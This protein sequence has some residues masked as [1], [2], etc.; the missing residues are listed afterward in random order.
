MPSLLLVD[1]EPSVI[2]T[3][4]MI[5]ERDGYA[6]STAT[7]Y[8][9]AA[10]LLQSESWDILITELD[11][12]AE[13][14]G[15]RLASEAKS[16]HHRPAIFVY[17]SY[18]NVERLRAALALRVDYCAFKPLEVDEIRKVVRLLLARNFASR[19]HGLQASRQR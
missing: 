16:L 12:E 14:L 13:A 2:A 1:P 11:L 4:K 17:A 19:N 5:L 8:S 6:V 18:P 15:L 7:S 9:A 10:A 3:L